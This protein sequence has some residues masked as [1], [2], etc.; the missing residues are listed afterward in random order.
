MSSK[1]K[2]QLFIPRGFAHA[3]L[4]LSES[5]IF[6]Y[7]VDNTYSPNHEDGII[8][9]DSILSVNWE[10]NIADLKISKKTRI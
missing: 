9:N 3:F 2:R 1:N 6:S 10:V 7:K 8:W 5:A 4:V